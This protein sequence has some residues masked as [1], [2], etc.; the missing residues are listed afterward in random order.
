MNT[1]GNREHYDRLTVQAVNIESA[2]LTRNKDIEDKFNGIQEKLNGVIEG[3]KPPTY[4]ELIFAADQFPE[5]MRIHLIDGGEGFNILCLL[6]LTD[7]GT[8]RQEF[9]CFAMNLAWMSKYAPD[10]DMK[11]TSLLY[12]VKLYLHL[13]DEHVE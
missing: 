11:K 2:K 6:N 4:A 5:A 3:N 8:T 10:N 1:S 13:R 9:K 12:L 7:G